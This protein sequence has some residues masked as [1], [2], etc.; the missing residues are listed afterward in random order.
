MT[1]KII[2]LRL[3]ALPIIVGKMEMASC[4]FVSSFTVILRYVLIFLVRLFYAKGTEAIHH[5]P[6]TRVGL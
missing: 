4:D 1:V 5:H 2:V 6:C 3:N